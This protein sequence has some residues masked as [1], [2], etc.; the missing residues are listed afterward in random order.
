MCAGDI[1]RIDGG[2]LYVNSRA[3][4][5]ILRSAENIYPA[6]VENRLDAH[7]CVQESAVYGV[8]DAV[9][10][11]ELSAWVAEALATYKV[12]TH[13]RLTS[14]ALPRNATGKVLKDQLR[15]QD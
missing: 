2:F 1:G 14:E 9:N 6:E 15:A 7:A 5:M 10:S 4:D 12:P 8:D 11:D 13:W 3:R